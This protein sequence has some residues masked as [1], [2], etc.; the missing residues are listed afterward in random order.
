MRAN[1]TLEGYVAEAIRQNAAAPAGTCFRESDL[2]AF[3]QGR[4]EDPDAV[5]EHLVGCRACL[6]LGRDTSLF[7]ES[8]SEAERGTVAPRFSLN[9][10]RLFALAAAAV[11]VA[12]TGLLLLRREA[13]VVV[14]DQQEAD[15]P[16][17]RG[18]PWLNLQIA[19]A[20]YAPAPE[21]EVIWRG[22]EESRPD[23]FVAAMKPY[24][25]SDYG[26]AEKELADLI[27]RDPANAPAHFYRGVSLLMLGRPV[28]AIPPLQAAVN[29]SRNEEREEARWYLALAH[30]KSGQLDAAAAMLDSIDGVHRDEARLQRQAIRE[31]L[32]H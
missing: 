20:E 2:I 6:D 32:A 8:L 12:A 16:A 11:F 1:A 14:R 30:L 18:N 21:D 22:G 13:P 7:V 3:Y 27:A 23:P 19:K 24:T 26:Q 4:S 9:A 25:T 31:Y 29:L 10:P 17:K 28:D 5:R 15:T